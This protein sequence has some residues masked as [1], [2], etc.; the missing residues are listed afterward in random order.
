MCMQKCTDMYSKIITNIYPRLEALGEH[1]KGINRSY[2]QVAVH[3]GLILEKAAH[4]VLTTDNS[5]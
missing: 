3:A 2:E 1:D 4:F 5:I